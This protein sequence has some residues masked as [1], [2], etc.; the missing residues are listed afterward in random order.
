M[1]SAGARDW[2]GK[3]VKTVLNSIFEREVPKYTQIGNA[4]PVKLALEIG[5]HFSKIIKEYIL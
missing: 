5:T 4:V 2:A 1:G 3:E